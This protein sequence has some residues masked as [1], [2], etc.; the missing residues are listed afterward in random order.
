M[1]NRNVIKRYE[2][3]YRLIVVCKE[4]K[5]D[6]FGFFSTNTPGRNISVNR[7]LEKNTL[8]SH[9]ID[10]VIK[11]RPGVIDEDLFTNKKNQEYELLFFLFFFVDRYERKEKEKPPNQM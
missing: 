10:I 11:K 6:S 3:S 5:K 7:Q 9:F 2:V 1:C 4:K 8:K